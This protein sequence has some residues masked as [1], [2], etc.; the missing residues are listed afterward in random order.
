MTLL[1]THSGYLIKRNEQHVWQKRWCCVVPHTFLYYF[2]AEREGDPVGII[3]LECYTSVNHGRDFVWELTGDAITNPDLRSFWFQ[4]DDEEDCELWTKALLG[5]RHSALRD[6]RDAYIQVC[7][8]FPLQ[9]SDLNDEINDAKRDKE[10]AEREL[11]R[12]RSHVEEGRRNVLKIVR[13]VLERAGERWVVG[14]ERALNGVDAVGMNGGVNKAVETLGECCSYVM[15]DRQKLME[16]NERLRKDLDYLEREKCDLSELEGF[17]REMEGYKKKVSVEKRRM[18][19]RID[20]LENLLQQ[21]RHERDSY[22]KNLQAKEMEF[23]LLSAASKQRIS[24]LSGHKKILKREVIDLRKKMDEVV[25]EVTAYRHKSLGLDD[26]VKAEKQRNEILER[27]LNQVESQIKMQERLMDCMMS[28]TGSVSFAGGSVIFNNDNDSVVSDFKVADMSVRSMRSEIKAPRNRYPPSLPPSLPPDNVSLNT[29][30]NLSMTSNTPV[31]NTNTI[32]GC[33]KEVINPAIV[34]QPCDRKKTMTTIDDMPIPKVFSESSGNTTEQTEQTE[35][36]TNVGLEDDVDVAATAVAVFDS[37]TTPESSEKTTPIKECLQPI[38][39]VRDPDSP[40][41]YQPQR[42]QRHDHSHPTISS[43]EHDDDDDDVSEGS[44]SALTEDRTH[45]GSS[46]NFSAARLNPP[47]KI[48]PHLPPSS[49]R[50]NN[51]NQ[52][53]HIR[54]MD[55]SHPP[56]HPK[57]C[58]AIP[59]LVS[60]ESCLPP[61]RRPPV[62]PHPTSSS[63]HNK[64]NNTASS[65]AVPTFKNLRVHTEREKLNLPPPRHEQFRHQTSNSSIVSS[66]RDDVSVSS[67]TSKMSVAQRARLDAESGC[68]GTPVKVVRNALPPAKKKTPTSLFGGWGRSF[69]EV[70][71]NSILGVKTDNCSTDSQYE[72]ETKMNLKERQM[73]Q[74]QKQLKFLKEQ[75]LLK[76]GGSHDNDGASSVASSYTA[77]KIRHTGS[78]G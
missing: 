54:P 55:D 53:M 77:S 56:H 14:L 9:L 72:A 66:T 68:S 15:S 31:P 26:K 35:Q 58:S 13:E 40:C 67:S 17:K 3:D 44:L 50:T 28:Q 71:D 51:N 19:E 22:S 16:E 10:D 4:G 21:T 60:E 74:R 5:D 7:E 43:P 70:M 18:E 34:K 65:A 25:S 41:R 62:Q 75:G 11:Y 30:I 42:F 59:S 29:S 38:I 33:S 78:L 39:T 24:E 20:S 61:S 1:S 12:V 69:T 49:S 47:T 73:M 2:D 48:Y 32:S 36:A 64:N 57:P 45:T 37:A 63:A 6:E 8:S 46:A 27:H 52:D 23:N 76:D